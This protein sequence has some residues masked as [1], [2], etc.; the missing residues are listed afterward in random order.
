MF[1]GLKIIEMASVMAGPAV[2]SF[3]SELGADVVKIENPRTGGDITRQWKLPTED[4]ASPASA[5]FASVNWNKL[6]LFLDLEDPANLEQVYGMIRNADILIC[7]WKKGDAE[8]FRLDHATVAA[9]NPG[10][11]Y[12]NINGFGDEEDRVAFDVVL[13]AETGWM[14]MNGTPASP[15]VKL[16]VAII[17][18]FAAHQLKEGILTALIRKMQTGKGSRVTVSLFDAAIASLA[19]QAANYI[20]AGH[21]PQRIGSLHPNIAPYG[22]IITCVE[23]TQI[24]LAIG[25]DKQFKALCTILGD[26]AL[27]EDPRY[28][29]NKD[30]VQNRNTLI[31]A[32]Q[33]RVQHFTCGSFLDLCRSHQVPAGAIR[34]LQQVFE[35]PTARELI[36]ADEVGKRVKSAIFRLE[37]IA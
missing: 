4:P 36:L 29:H 9:I 15:P 18:Q 12:A 17:D 24:V 23:G 5:Y 16:P 14:Y 7:N 1:K 2:G 32:L 8:K 11:I 30:R 22:E 33:Q 27:A 25:S 35:Q 13:Q 31:G 10:I 26:P 37:D 34:N 20:T 19:N 28:R 21:I 3:F 6:H